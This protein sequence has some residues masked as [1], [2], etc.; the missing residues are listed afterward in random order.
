[1]GDVAACAGLRELG[2][3]LTAGAWEGLELGRRAQLRAL[4]G[5]NSLRKCSIEGMCAA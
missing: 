1:M 5:G 4:Q 2:L 3:G